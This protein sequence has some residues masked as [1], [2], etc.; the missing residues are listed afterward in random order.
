MHDASGHNIVLRTA[1][2]FVLLLCRCCKGHQCCLLHTSC[3]VLHA[4]PDELQCALVSVVDRLFGKFQMDNAVELFTAVLDAIY[5]TTVEAYCRQLEHLLLKCYDL[6]QA[7]AESQSAGLIT[8]S[9]VAL[10]PCQPPATSVSTTPQTATA[11]APPHA[12]A[13]GLEAQGTAGSTS[14]AAPPEAAASC[15][16]FQQ[17]HVLGEQSYVCPTIASQLTEACAELL[18]ARV[19]LLAVSMHSILV[20]PLSLRSQQAVQQSW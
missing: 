7:A 8:P 14:A 5:N 20:H 13:P 17:R 4:H 9:A 1:G 15:A 10:A 18:R 16:G 19:E 6:Q 12:Y 3:I 2:T 11:I